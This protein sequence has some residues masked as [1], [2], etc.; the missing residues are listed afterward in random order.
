MGE[1]RGIQSIEVGGRLLR[2]LLTAGRALPLKEL[3]LAA[4]MRPAKAHPY[5]VSYARL[6][7]VTQH[8][9][10]APYG[11]GPMALALGLLALQQHDPLRR[12]GEALPALADQTGCTVALAVWGPAGPTVVRVAEAPAPLHMSLRLGTVL[13]LHQ[14]ATGQALAAQRDAAEVDAL[15][16]LQRGA[17]ARAR[18]A[19][20]AWQAQLAQVRAQGYASSDEALLA[21]V[22]ALAVAE[23]QGQWALLAVAPRGQWHD[24]RGRALPA[25]DR[26]RRA[27]AALIP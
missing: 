14:T 18:G 23:P 16:R 15:W 11:L 26:V 7:L 6:G 21:G 4:G 9:E 5:L 12:T 13:N 25:R 24:A 22:A 2:A 1:A 3:A 20:A 10:G 27:L 17:A 8:G 19:H